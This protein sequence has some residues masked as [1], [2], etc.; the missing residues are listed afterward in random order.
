MERIPREWQAALETHEVQANDLFA[1]RTPRPKA[2]ELTLGE[3]S[4]RFLNLKLQQVEAAALS[5]CSSVAY[6]AIPD[7]LMA[8]F[9]KGPLVKGL[10]ADNN[11]SGLSSR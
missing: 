2:D 1:A 4:D 10:A 9:A 5:P 3:L 6:R 8:I 11:A 7:R